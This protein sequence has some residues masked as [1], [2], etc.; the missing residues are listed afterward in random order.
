MNNEVKYIIKACFII[1]IVVTGFLIFQYFKNDKKIQVTAIDDSKIADAALQI[2]SVYNY[3]EL[4]FK[5]NCNACHKPG[6][7]DQ[8]GFTEISERIPDKNLL[9]AFI[10]NSDSVIESGDKY[11]KTM[12]EDFN[13]ISMPLFEN[14]SEKDIDAILLYIK[15]EKYH[16]S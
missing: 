5:K 9:I 13:G 15:L 1:G 11:F 2:D 8:F 16:R 14:L 4:L 10:K 6:S 12:F 3:G 7:T